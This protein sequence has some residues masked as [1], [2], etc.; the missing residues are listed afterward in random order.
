M[1]Y[2][3]GSYLG[4]MWLFLAGHAH[5]FIN[6]WCVDWG[7]AGLGCPCLGWLSSAHCVISTRIPR[8]CSNHGDRVERER[9]RHPNLGSG[10]ANCCCCRITLAKAKFH[11]QH[12]FKE[13]KKES[14]FCG[15]EPQSHSAKC[16]IIN[17]PHLVHLHQFVS[18][19]L[20]LT[21]YLGIT[22][23]AFPVILWGDVDLI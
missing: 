7:S 4:Q 18:I 10:L 14:P 11:G 9:K 6:G 1:G 15:E 22:Y 2:L 12:R 16:I 23:P 21:W 8:A 20:L 3:S 13:Q 17:I 5:V 19:P